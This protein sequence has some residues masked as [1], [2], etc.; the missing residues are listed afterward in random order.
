M[1]L[2]EIQTLK[3]GFRKQAEK[4]Q[5]DKNLSDYGRRASLKQ[6][7]DAKDAALLAMV[8]NLRH[9]AVEIGS[10][11]SRIR[12]ACAALESMERDSLN[13][14]RLSFETEAIR[15]SLDACKGDPDGTRQLLASIRRLGDTYKLRAFLDTVGDYFPNN[16]RREEEWQALRSEMQAAEGS[17]HDGEYQKY[18]GEEKSLLENLRAVEVE[19]EFLTD[20][21]SSFLVKENVRRSVF[22]GLSKDEDGTLQVNFGNTSDEKPEETE[23]RLSD[24]RRQMEILQAEYFARFNLP[25]NPLTDGVGPLDG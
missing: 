18:A 11:V 24:E 6:L 20:E 13:Y 21:L 16:G 14:Q 2:Q 23:K 1:T 12:G 7:S 19:S 3:D 9:T 8:P 10:K 5:K 25:Y 17:V 15:H 22:A 4:I